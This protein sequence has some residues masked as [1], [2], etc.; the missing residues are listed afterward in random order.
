MT[1]NNDR[2]QQVVRAFVRWARVANCDTRLGSGVTWYATGEG[3]KL[4]PFGANWSFEAA[5]MDECVEAFAAKIVVCI[6]AR[7]A[8]SRA[9]YDAALAC[10]REYET[11]LAT[12]ART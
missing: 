7:V 5:T 11:M 2:L 3:W 8:E 1:F 12:P 4:V 9:A 6:N 10:L